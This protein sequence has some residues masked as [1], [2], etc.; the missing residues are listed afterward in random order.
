[1]SKSDQQG[2]DPMRYDGVFIGPPVPKSVFYRGYR[3]H[4]VIAFKRTHELADEQEQLERRES[5][6]K[7]QERRRRYRAKEKQK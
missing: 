7:E 1:M 3:R 5:K 6:R 4:S 2:D